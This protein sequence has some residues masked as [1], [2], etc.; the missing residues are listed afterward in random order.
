[1]ISKCHYQFLE[2]Q[3][4]FVN[5]CKLIK[6]TVIEIVLKNVLK[7]EFF[8]VI[9]FIKFF[10]HLLH[11]YFVLNMNINFQSDVEHN[12]INSFVVFSFSVNSSLI[13]SH[14]YCCEFFNYYKC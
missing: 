2:L 10:L 6:L 13:F 5:E 14:D 3:N 12:K 9:K 1:L 7:I 11:C 4:I 8:N